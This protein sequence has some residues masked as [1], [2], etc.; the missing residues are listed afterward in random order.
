MIMFQINCMSYFTFFFDGQMSYFSVNREIIHYG[1]QSDEK[2]YIVRDS[3]L[4]LQFM[5][6]FVT[7]LQTHDNCV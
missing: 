2:G 1:S 5:L 6:W 7:M 4:T 3:F